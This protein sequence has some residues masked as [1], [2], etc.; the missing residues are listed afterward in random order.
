MLQT[1][2]GLP[3]AISDE[4]AKQLAEAVA[5]ITAHYGVQISKTAVVWS[6][7]I[8]TAAMI[9]GPRA[10]MVVGAMQEAKRNKRGG[11]RGAP[12]NVV[13]MAGIP[14]GNVTGSEPLGG[15]PNGTDIHTTPGGVQLG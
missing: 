2:T 11:N 1:F 9:Y 10:L 15:G 12:G 8:A 13:D 3:L 6:N 4:E 14:V 7:L 5:A